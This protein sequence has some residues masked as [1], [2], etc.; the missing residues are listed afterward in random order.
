MSKFRIL[1]KLL[2]PLLLIALVFAS[3]GSALAFDD[4]AGNPAKEA[5]EQLKQEGVVSGID[6]RSFKPNDVMTNAQAVHLIVKGMNLN[7]HAIKFIKQPLASDYFTNVPND[8]WYAE[9]FIVAQLNS[10]PL[11]KDIDPNKPISREFFASLLYHALLKTGDYAFIELFVSVKDGDDVSEGHM[12]SIQKLLIAKIAKLDENGKFYPRK[13]ITR[14]DAAAML[15]AAMLFVNE[16]AVKQPND[17]TVTVTGEKVNEEVTRYTL[18]WGIKPN[19]G[20]RL[21]IDGIQF[22]GDEAVISYSLHLPEEG[23]SYIQVL[24]EAKASTYVSSAYNVTIKK[25]N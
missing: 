12:E 9:S 18:S 10:L 11:P 19:P 1:N 4:L 15:H 8:A 7:L 24:T 14:G 5:I 21:T 23:H 20:Y 17:E 3:A 25:S 2:F 16:H 22:I 13:A 6:A